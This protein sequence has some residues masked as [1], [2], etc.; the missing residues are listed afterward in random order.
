MTELDI[1]T[2]GIIKD[3]PRKIELDAAKAVTDFQ[4][5]EDDEKI[6]VLVKERE[7]ILMEKALAQKKSKFF[8]AMS[9]ELTTFDDD[10]IERI[11]KFQSQISEE[12]TVIEQRWNKAAETGNFETEG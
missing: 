4:A 1:V 7:A 10:A 9:N 6:R 12:R 5:L 8:Q 2:P 3:E 11:G